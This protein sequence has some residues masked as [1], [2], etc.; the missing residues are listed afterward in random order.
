MNES[1]KLTLEEGNLDEVLTVIFYYVDE[2]Y[3]QVSHVV[4]RTGPKPTFSDSEVITLTLVNQM[5]IDS[6]TAWYKFIKRNHK[7]LFPHLI[8]RS[9]YHRRSKSLFKVTNL[10]R[11]M[12]LLHLDV[13]LQQWHL[14]DSM[15]VPVC[16]YTRAGRAHHFAAQLEVTHD[17]LYGHCAA[18]KMDFYGF[19]LHLMV[20]TQGIV[21]HFV[22]A[23]GS[24]HDVTVAPEL[25]ETYRPDIVVGA[26]KGYVGLAK[27]LTHS[28]DYQLIVQQKSNQAPNTAL[29]KTF[30]NRF[31][32]RIE[33]T[34]AQLS[35]QF[36]MQY[37]RAKSAWGLLSR[38]INKL[39]AHTLAIYLNSLAD[40]PLLALKSIIF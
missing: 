34:N 26:D 24:H 9:R 30:L 29:E 39:T 21:A 4:D 23:P 19:R 18:K 35:E 12:L 32:K 15:P 10:I 37:T 17:S 7:A 16:G 8:E 25:L 6:E 1:L 31:R 22:L 3:N 38:V 33:T 40:R 36:N 28:I 27:R 14:M 13:H 20:T 2:F 11:Q 5:A